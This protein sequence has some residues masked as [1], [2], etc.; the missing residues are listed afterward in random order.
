MIQTYHLELYQ[1]HEQLFLIPHRYLENFST[2]P[3]SYIGMPIGRWVND[4]LEPAHEF[5]SR[6]GR[7][8]TRGLIRIEDERVDQWIAGRDIRHPNTGLEPSGQYLLVT[9]E[10]GRNLGLGKLLPKRLRNML[11]RGSV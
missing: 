8:F 7:Q 11:P 1:R 9:D 6:F 10:T 2:L 3:Y 5:I 4:N